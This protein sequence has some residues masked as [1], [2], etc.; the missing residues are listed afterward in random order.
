MS[1]P[2]IWDANQML[3]V[4]QEFAQAHLSESLSQDEEYADLL[5]KIK[6]LVKTSEGAFQ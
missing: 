3:N 4:A 1:V 6:Q 5:R 2:A